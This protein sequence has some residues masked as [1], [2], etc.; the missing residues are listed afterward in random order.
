MLELIATEG[1]EVARIVGRGDGDDRLAV[2][3]DQVAEALRHA[4]QR[5]RDAGSWRSSRLVPS[6]PAARTTPR[7]GDRLHPRPRHSAPLLTCVT[8]YASD[9]SA[10][11]GAR[12]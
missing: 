9:P 5:N 11:V 8:A 10:A 6:A 4:R 2:G 3:A 1:S 7:A 12:R